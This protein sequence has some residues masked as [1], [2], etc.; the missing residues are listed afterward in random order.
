[1]LQSS[2]KVVYCCQHHRL[3]VFYCW[4]SLLHCWCSHPDQLC[5]YTSLWIL[6]LSP[7]IAAVSWFTNSS[8]TGLP[9]DVGSTLAVD[10][11]SFFW[12][13]NTGTKALS[14]KC[15]RYVNTVFPFNRMDEIFVLTKQKQNCVYLELMNRI[16]CNSSPWR[17]FRMTHTW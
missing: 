2:L 16:D 7:S 15:Q 17:S 1:M 5:F 12:T 4:F 10:F 14:I 8:L 9:V 3:R 13:E 11:V 6:T